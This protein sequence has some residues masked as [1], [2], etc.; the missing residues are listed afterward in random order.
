MEEQGIEMENGQ[1]VRCSRQDESGMA[2]QGVLQQAGKLSI[3]GDNHRTH[4]L[5]S[6]ED[7]IVSMARQSDVANVDSVVSSLAQYPGS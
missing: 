4:G 3:S 7:F 2:T 1:L 5:R 6:R